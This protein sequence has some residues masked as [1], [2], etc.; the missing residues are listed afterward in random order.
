MFDQLTDDPKLVLE[1]G[2]LVGL[3]EQQLMTYRHEGFWEC[4]DNSREFQLLNELWAAAMRPARVGFG[5]RGEW[6]SSAILSLQSP[7]A[8]C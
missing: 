2:P 6:R 7:Q 1:H 5:S 4:M 8:P 3:R